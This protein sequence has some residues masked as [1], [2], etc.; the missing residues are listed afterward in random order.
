MSHQ[1]PFP[2]SGLSL[3][4]SVGARNRY[5][6][7]RLERSKA[8]G[9]WRSAREIFMEPM[10]LLLVASAVVYFFAGAAAEAWFMLGAVVLVAA[11]SLYQDLRSRHALEALQ[12]FTQPYAAVIRDDRLVRLPAE[13]VVVGDYVVAS[14]GELIIADGF[15]R[16]V[17]DFSVNESILTG[18]AYSVFKDAAGQGE[19]VFSGT[20]VASG[21][22]VFEVSAVGIHTRLGQIG[23]SIDTTESVKTPLQIQIRSFVRSMALA[24]TFIFLLIWLINWLRSEDLAESLLRGLTIAMS[25]LPEEIPVAF[26]SFMALGAYRL[27]QLGIIVKQTATVEALGSATV[28]CTDKTGTITENRMDVYQCYVFSS[29][30]IYD[31]DSFNDPAVASLLRSAMWASETV[32]FDSME[33]ALHQLYGEIHPIDERP[34]Y[35]MAHEYPLSGIPPMMTHVFENNEGQRIIACKGAPEALLA[36]SALSPEEVERV[37][38]VNSSFAQQ[39]LRVLAVGTAIPETTLPENQEAFSFRFEGLIA[40]YDPPKKN[41]NQVFSSLKRAGI[42]VKLVTGDN[43]ETAM[44]ISRQAGLSGYQLAI[45]GPELSELQGEAFDKAVQSH[46]IFSRIYPELKLRIVTSLEQQ[47]EIVGMTGDGVND[48]PA[49]KAAHIGIAMGAR[50]SEIAKSA[51]SLILTDD[52]LGRMIDAVAMGRRIYTNL[53]KAIQY[54]ISIHIPIILT[55]AIPSVLGWVYPAIFT[56]VHVIFLELIMGPT[57]SIIYEREP[58]EPNSMEQPPRPASKTFFSLRELAISICQG[59]GITAATLLIYLYG[60]KHQYS[61]DLIRSMVFSTLIFAN[62]FLTLVNRS[63]YYSVITT[64]HYKNSLLLAMLGLTTIMLLALLY[65]PVLSHFFR[66]V[67]LGIGPLALCLFAAIIAV[68]IFEGYKFLKRRKH[69]LIIADSNQA[70]S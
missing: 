21:Q 16:Q 65:V 2:F 17:N 62:I 57:C 4:E 36:H 28:L 48:G 29:E 22:C 51:A 49:L 20:L 44:A 3:A 35:H 47:G 53:K 63:F 6:T 54:I 64:L 61:E 37:K 32:P 34:L 27:M 66:L 52:D 7:N 56:P 18:E 45:S 42:R 39:G 50:G 14:E 5:G 46:T 58:S 55:V 13:E 30:H 8:L 24:G 69:R 1:N 26:A 11:I 33:R 43:P 10:F 31:R 38:T 59:L 15:L 60:V 25:I 40:F 70:K 67:P 19:Q 12:A 9:F 41:I 68:G 23:Q